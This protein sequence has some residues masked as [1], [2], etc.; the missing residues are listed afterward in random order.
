MNPDV[1]LLMVDPTLTQ[2]RKEFRE[3]LGDEDFTE[4]GHQILYF[5][6]KTW[7]EL[8]AYLRG[9]WGEFSTDMNIEIPCFK[10]ICETTLWCVK[11]NQI[12][13][14]NRYA[15]FNS[16]ILA[17]NKVK[18]ERFGV[19]RNAVATESFSPF[20]LGLVNCE[21]CSE[22]LFKWLDEN[23]IDFKIREKPNGPLYYWDP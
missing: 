17:W 16:R 4:F 13:T 18:P 1:I 5:L 2:L 10:T 20:G 6:Y 15:E 3:F 22:L 11:H 9:V 12:V 23:S 14:F 21:K 19:A 8:P 7:R